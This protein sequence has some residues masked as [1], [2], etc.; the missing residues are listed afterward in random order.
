MN[1][2]KDVLREILPAEKLAQVP[3]TPEEIAQAKLRLHSKNLA[4]VKCPICRD[5]GFVHPLG[6]NNRPDYTRIIDCRCVAAKREA[7]RQARYMK[8]CELPEDTEDRTLETYRTMGFEILEEVKQAALDMLNGEV[9]F[10]SLVSDVDRGKTHIAIALC[11]KWLAMKRTAK[12]VYVPLLL[13][14]L[15]QAFKYKDGENS[16]DYKFEFYLNVQLLALDDLF[17][18]YHK[19][20]GD[21]GMEKL[22]TIIDYRHIHGL[23][24]II[25]SNKGLDEIDMLSPMIRSRMVRSKNS[26]VIGIDSPEYITIKNKPK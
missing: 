19:T 9:T 11:R 10:L 4:S 18:E 26:R 15:R 13:H 17:R 25:T 12:Y 21:W 7:D 2:I 14:E 23:P 24:T 5:G 8:L 6:E 3:Q 1:S 20:E 22:E 16:Y